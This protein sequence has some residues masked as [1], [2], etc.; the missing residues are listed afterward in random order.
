M[1]NEMDPTV[2]EEPVQAAMKNQKSISVSL[3]MEYDSRYI[4]YTPIG[5]VHTD[6]KQYR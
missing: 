4:I 3:A 2:D 1:L 5:V 6:K